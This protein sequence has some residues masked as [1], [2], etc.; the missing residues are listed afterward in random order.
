MNLK[1]SLC[2][3]VIGIAF[4][5]SL[6]TA[7]AN[8]L[9]PVSSKSMN[10]QG[11]ANYQQVLKQSTVLNNKDAALVKKVGKKIAAAS[12]KYFALNPNKKRPAEKFQWEFNLLKDNTPNAW[13]MP[14]GKVAVLTGILPY[15]KDETGLAVVMSHEVS[16]AILEHGKKQTNTNVVKNIGGLIVAKKGGSLAQTA[17]KYGSNLGT[18][19]Y[20]RTHETQSDELGL[21]LM[22][23]A[24]YDPNKA[25]AFWQRMSSGK[26][27]E[28]PQFLS[29]HPSDSTRIKNIQNFLKSEKY[30]KAIGGK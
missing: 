24:G 20:S 18:L 21:I 14:G 6:A 8:Y 7:Q 25:T 5:S 11:A 23:L 19:K 2:N 13:C 16:H 3:V 22:K 9:L 4:F 17:Y 28:T 30:K 10:N 15:T 27:S 1:K 29:T 26:G 12:E